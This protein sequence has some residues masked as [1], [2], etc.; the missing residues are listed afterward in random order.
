[1]RD[2][3]CE[4]PMGQS[5]VQNTMKLSAVLL[6]V[7]VLLS[8]LYL[9]LDYNLAEKG[10]THFLLRK[11]MYITHI[12]IPN[13]QEDSFVQ[14][15]F[16]STACLCLGRRTATISFLPSDLLSFPPDPDSSDRSLRPKGDKLANM[17]CMINYTML[18]VF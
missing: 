18:S 13:I 2:K 9:A 4:Q 17:L 11:A 12:V 5:E 16:Y 7:T 8:C 14:A 10:A 3:P 1:M 15:W 6:A